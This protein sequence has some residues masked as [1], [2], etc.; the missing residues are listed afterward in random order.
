[1]LKFDEEK[2]DRLE[3]DYPGIKEQIIRFEEAPLPT[4]PH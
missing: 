3:N 2:L 4:C 1:M